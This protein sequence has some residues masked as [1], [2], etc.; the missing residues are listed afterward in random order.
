MNEKAFYTGECYHRVALNMV[1]DDWLDN[2]TNDDGFWFVPY[3]VN[4]A[5][6]CEL[7]LKALI[8]N[9]ERVSGHK[10]SDLFRQLSTEDKQEI[11]STPCFKGDSNFDCKIVEN[12]KSFEEW[13]YYFEPDKS[14]SVDI[15]FMEN[16]AMVL[17]DIIAKKL[18]L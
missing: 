16:F 13:R 7:Y 8:S 1:P 10:W 17:H 18:D 15:V 11:L 14:V 2:A 6:A 9:G 5:F 4:M 12:E 3:V